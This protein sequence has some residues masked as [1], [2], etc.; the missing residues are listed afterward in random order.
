MNCGLPFA[1][2]TEAG[3][4]LAK[5]LLH[6]RGRDDVHVLALPRGGVPV[7]A[8]VASALNAP[9]DVL[10]VRKL[11]VPGH[12]EF[13]MGAIA[14]GG[15]PVMNT[16][17]TEAL[18][19]PVETIAAVVEREGRE[20][21]RR[22]RLYRG[23]RPALNLFGH[24][25]VLVDDGLATGSTM[26]AAVGAVRAQHPARVVVG[27]PVAAESSCEAM[28]AE[29]D[30]VICLHTPEPFRSVGLWYQDFSQTSD[31]QVRA[32]LAS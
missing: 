5:R 15:I 6:L 4:A 28:R 16:K 11:G 9:L 27:V 14:S 23:D 30:E 26:L 13:A 1:D 8:E 10:I 17:V 29:A 19:I 25:V 2:R 32:L 12:E 24:V 18:Q 20:L 3:A 22:E 31:E 7:A 21:A